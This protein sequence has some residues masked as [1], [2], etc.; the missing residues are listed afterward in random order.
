MSSTC[1]TSHPEIAPC[2]ASAAV[3][4]ATADTS[5]ALSVKTP[6]V[7]Q[8]YAA[9]WPENASGTRSQKMPWSSYPNMS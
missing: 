2:A 3:T 4:L 7:V 9:Y 1:D 8:V 5:E 6:G